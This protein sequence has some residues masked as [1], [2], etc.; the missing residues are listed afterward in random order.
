[1]SDAEDAPRAF[2]RARLKR[3]SLLACLGIALLPGRASAQ[4][5]GAASLFIEDLGSRTVAILSD[6][7]A[8]AAQKLE[9]LVDLLNQATDLALVAR[10][11]MGRHWRTAS[12]AQQEEFVRLFEGLVVKTMAERLTSYGGETFRITADRAAD[13][14][15]SIVSTEILRPSGGAPLQVDW[16]VRRTGSDHAIIDIVAEGISMVVTHRSEVSEIVSR[17]GIDGLIETM[18]DR[19]QQPA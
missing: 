8:S 5:A 7:S 6:D 4:A 10:L 13:E 19:L 9:Q 15:D 12:A 11:V 16:R 3:R 18:R 17:R 1:M 2:G 14:R